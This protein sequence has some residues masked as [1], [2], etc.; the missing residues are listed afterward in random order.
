MLD[1]Q[2]ERA[3][4]GD[5]E[6]VYA[7]AVKLGERFGRL[8]ERPWRVSDSLSIRSD[9]ERHAVQAFVL[10]YRSLPESQRSE[11]PALLH[12]VAKLEMASGDFDLAQKDFQLVA[13]MVFDPS[14]QAEPHFAAYE[15]ALQCRKWDQ[16]LAELRQAMEAAPKRFAPFPLDKYEAERIIGAGG[17]GVVFLCKQKRS[18]A[19]VVIKALRTD[20]LERSV[21]DLFQ[22][23][24]ALEQVEHPN[25][26][27]LRDCDF[28]DQDATRPYLVMDYFD[29]QTLDEYVHEHG[30]MSIADFQIVG[31][32]IAE[33]LH[34]AHQKGVLHRDVKPRN[35]LVRKTGDQWTVKLI[36]FGLA[37]RRD[38]LSSATSNTDA[39]ER[40][41]QGNTIAG[42]LDFS[43]PEQLGKLKEPFAV[44]TYSDVYGFARTCC[45]ALF[46]THQPG[47]RQWRAVT[48]AK[49]VDLLGEALMDN[50]RER[51]QDF[52]VVLDR[53]PTSAP[54]PTPEPIAPTTGIGH[55]WPLL[56]RSIMSAG[57][58]MIAFALFAITVGFLGAYGVV[59]LH[60]S[61]A[62]FGIGAFAA[63]A[64]LLTRWLNLSN[65]RSN[66]TSAVLVGSGM[67]TM[68][69]TLVD[70]PLHWLIAAPILA[71]LGL[72]CG[73]TVG[74]FRSWEYPN[75]RSPHLVG[76][77]LLFVLAFVVNGGCIALAVGH[78][79]WSQAG[80]L[81]FPV[82]G[83]KPGNT[84][85]SKLP[86]LNRTVGEQSPAAKKILTGVNFG[87]PSQNGMKTVIFD[88][89]SSTLP[90]SLTKGST[91]PA[92]DWTTSKTNWE[93]FFQQ[94]DGST[95]YLENKENELRFR[96][97][98][99]EIEVRFT[100]DNKTERVR[101]TQ[102]P[103]RGLRL[104]SASSY[105][106]SVQAMIFRKGDPF[107]PDWRQL[108]WEWRWTGPGGF[109][110]SRSLSN[111]ESL[112]HRLGWKY[113]RDVRPGQVI[114]HVYGGYGG[115]LR[116]FF[117][118]DGKMAIR[119][120]QN[121]PATAD[122]IDIGTEFPP[123]SLFDWPK[124]EPVTK[125][126][127]G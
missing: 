35:V 46:G 65:L 73:T 21:Q 76:S 25:V 59:P 58:G 53:W 102:F 112:F 67:G 2:L 52:D 116:L 87:T 66:M 1:L 43:A 84:S 71:V 125:G 34:A 31:R 110:W 60:L 33:G 16:A 69:G 14:I 4:H 26:I 117:P 51:P 42:T 68:Y 121:Q 49:L 57:V 78:L 75:A 18:Q 37:L 39:L 98:E 82:Y 15:A 83:V 126:R 10:Q 74:L 86:E 22:E 127:N 27:R 119:E 17:F 100:P 90:E 36:D 9:A 41:I 108:H 47:P 79:Y 28:V 89:N 103:I 29:G 63:L 11:M 91:G 50:P 124:M 107:P 101:I 106:N 45:F 24:A 114:L 77:I 32:Q 115:Y 23:A 12:A 13:Q 81:L 44:G 93:I 96:F 40:T 7:E 118:W 94:F 70:G 99:G 85:I 8:H 97:D 6:A 88:S 19:R 113:E 122:R 123:E 55:R 92:L 109:D 120:F 104:W 105:P 30:P 48:D 20:D 38:V 95:N 64:F 111:W 80:E 54:K 3:R 72:L 62:F 56:S 5:K 61:G